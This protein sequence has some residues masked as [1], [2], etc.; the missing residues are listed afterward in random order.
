MAKV[1]DVEKLKPILADILN[2]ENET[3]VI[4]GIMAVAEDYDE[5]AINARISDAVEAAKAEAEK[6]YGAKL[7]D[8]FFGGAKAEDTVVE[9]DTN[10]DEEISSG[11]V[12]V[13]DIF[14]EVK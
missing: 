3:G 14:E 12:E 9:D 1:V 8:M 5:E 10:V 4:E 6:S 2:E 13:K 11:A 7:H